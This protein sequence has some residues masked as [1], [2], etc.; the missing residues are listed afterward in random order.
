[1]KN[2]VCENN[3]YKFVYL[4]VENQNIKTVHIN[5]GKEKNYHFFFIGSRKKCL[6]N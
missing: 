3:L 2:K 6:R 5:T 4:E 1:M